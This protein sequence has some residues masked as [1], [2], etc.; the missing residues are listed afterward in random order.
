MAIQETL[1]EDA[2]QLR[3]QLLAHEAGP[4][5][6]AWARIAASLK[7]DASPATAA[8]VRRISRYAFRYAASIAAGLAL[9]S[10]LAYLFTN[11]TRRSG[12]GNLSTGIT[13]HKAVNAPVEKATRQ[14]D[15]TLTDTPQA[16]PMEASTP[17]AEQVAPPAPAL[18]KD[19]QTPTNLAVRNDKPAGVTQADRQKN[20]GGKPGKFSRI[21][22]RD[23]NYILVSD[24]SGG[25]NR[26]NY[27]LARMVESLQDEGRVER[28]PGEEA[29]S[30]SSRLASWQERM[31]RSTFIP[32]PGNFFDIAEM[33]AMLTDQQ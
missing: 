11:D 22:Y 21:S 1:A 5:P 6:E 10:V 27:K 25:W 28:E 13:R 29:D 26:V 24:G 9:L 3:Q 30:W 19:I 15:V 23:R 12:I 14:G 4:P 20:P 18:R 2:P 33:A 17:Q 32:S 16:E 31:E 8:P 7:E